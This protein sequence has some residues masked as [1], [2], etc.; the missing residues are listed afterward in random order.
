MSA[1]KRDVLFKICAMGCALLVLGAL[2][3][4]GWLTKQKKNEPANASVPG[5]SETV[6]KGVQKITLVAA[7]DNMISDTMIQAAL[8]ADNTYDFTAMYAPVKQLVSDADF[9]IVNQETILGGKEFDYSGY[10]L[11]NSPWEVGEAAVNTG[12][13]VFLC[14]NDHAM[15]KGSQGILNAIQF[16][17]SKPNITFAGIHGD[18]TDYDSVKII[19]KNGVKIALLNYTLGTNG[20][21]L[22][23]DKP[24]LVSPL[25]KEKIAQDIAAA[26][27]QADVVA[28]FPHWGI[29]Y[30]AD[31]STAQAELAQFFC[32]NGA[33]L[34]I[35]SHPHVLEPV[36]WLES[37]AG[38]RT[39]VYYSLGNFLAHQNGADR[40]LGALASIT[41]TKENGKVAVDGTAIP[42]VNHIAKT[43]GQWQFKVYP[44]KDYTD[45]LAAAHKE[46][47]LTLKYLQ[48]LSAKMLGEFAQKS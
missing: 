22:P 36:Q 40:M 13:D 17:N 24:W 33:Q 41:I 11:Y 45:A 27:Q 3:L 8:Q 32:D 38:N 6:S 42:I 7:G 48:D 31:V 4:T 29:E 34:V 26:K 19:E 28:V 5:Q 23:E 1:K 2:M 30:V 10:P 44:L 43:D 47:Q 18:K 16:F 21:E 35:G 14:A 46:E 20:I 15:D 37:A 12:F 25:E 9:A 39:L